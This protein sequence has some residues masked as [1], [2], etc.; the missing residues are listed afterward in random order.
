MKQQIT[1]ISVQQA[2]KLCGLIYFFLTCLIVPVGV[3][4]L[5]AGGKDRI[6]GLIFLFAPL[7]YGT[8]GYLMG[9][10]MAFIYNLVA[11]HFGGLEYT[12]HIVE[13]E[14]RENGVDIIVQ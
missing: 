2:G 8:A 4:S 3:V 11:R 9:L 10:F 1:H 6:M 7:M 12:V 5:L 14:A 13:S